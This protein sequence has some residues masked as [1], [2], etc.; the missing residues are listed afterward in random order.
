M[1]NDIATRYFGT[2]ES[3]AA[4]I[5]AAG[6]HISFSKL[7]PGRDSDDPDSL[8]IVADIVTPA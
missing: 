4:E 7:T 6:F 2:P 3:L 8:T 1:Y 5:V